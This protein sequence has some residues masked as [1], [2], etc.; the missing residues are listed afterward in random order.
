MKKVI[1]PLCM[2]LVLCVALSS[3]A[4]ANG[5]SSVSTSAAP[6]SVQSAPSGGTSET[7]S[8]Q[9]S[10]ASSGSVSAIKETPNGTYISD[11]TTDRLFEDYALLYCSA[12]LCGHTWDDPSQIDTESLIQFYWV[13]KARESYAPPT[14]DDLM[15]HV[16]AADLEGYIMSYFNIDPKY[17]ET[18]QSY[19]TDTECYDLKYPDGLGMFPP[20]YVKVEKKD[21]S[22]DFYLGNTDYKETMLIYCK[23]TVELKE[24]GSF[25]YIAGE[26][27]EPGIP[28]SNS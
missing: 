1:L 26:A 4:T 27:Y 18:D 16:P 22:I 8:K 12:A 5:S 25:R 11:E 19:N 14:G 21:N 20:E 13:N 24:D 9:N 15:I 2:V 23:L 7:S 10:Q 6:N 17:L 3:C 28:V